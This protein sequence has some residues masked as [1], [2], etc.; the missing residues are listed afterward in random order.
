MSQYFGDLDTVEN[1][2]VYQENVGRLS[3]LLRIRPQAVVCDMHPLYET[4]RY[5]RAYARAYSLPL[6]QVQ[7]HHAHVASVMAE[8]NLRGSVIGV[9]FDGTGY[10]TDGCIWGGEILLC[11]GGSCQRFSHL[12]YT[13]MIGGDSSM[14]DAHRSALSFMAAAASGTGSSVLH[15]P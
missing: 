14:K 11:E 4:T 9:S 10:G 3:K 6:L 1:Q 15:R 12:Q 5:A 13:E 7:H 2:K 8:N